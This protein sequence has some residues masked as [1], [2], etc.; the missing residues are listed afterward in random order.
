MTEQPEHEKLSRVAA[1]SQV[2]CEFIEWLASR[3]THLMRW[4]EDD[5]EVTC[6]GDVWHDCNDGRHVG[7]DGR[8]RGACR[9]CDGRGTTTAHREGWV[10]NGEYI[11][12]LLAKFFEIDQAKLE[13]EKRAMI[14]TLQ[15]RY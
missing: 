1:Q 15:G 12:T 5:E 14:A 3:G 11:Q 4:Y 6:Y 10:P 8:D 7:T 9:V 2:V 13:W